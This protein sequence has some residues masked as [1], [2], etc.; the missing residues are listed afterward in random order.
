MTP[1]KK[2][3]AA[4]LGSARPAQLA[5]RPRPRRSRSRRRPRHGSGR[6]A[7]AATWR[8][9]GRRGAGPGARVGGRRLLC[10]RIT[11]PIG[12]TGRETRPG[13]PRRRGAA[14][15][16]T[17]RAGS[18]NRAFLQRKRYTRHRLLTRSELPCYVFGTRSSPGEAEPEP[19]AGDGSASEKSTK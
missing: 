10:S 8:R 15:R 3:M 4:R 19:H 5:P 7:C 12:V 17:P 11:R 14:A 18:R 2:F 9:R 13:R 16:Q 1:R 6:R